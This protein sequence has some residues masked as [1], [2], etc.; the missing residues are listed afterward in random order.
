MLSI[1]YMAHLVKSSYKRREDL[2]TISSTG[3]RRPYITHA[4]ELL[5]ILGEVNTAVTG[6][7]DVL[8]AA[9]TEYDEETAHAMQKELHQ[10][11]VTPINLDFSETDPPCP[12]QCPSEKRVTD[13]HMFFCVL[14]VSSVIAD[15]IRCL[16]WLRHGRRFFA[17]MKIGVWRL[18]S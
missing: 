2:T 1:S 18:Q 16:W 8:A 3:A 9:R 7:E 6:I 14:D 10:A 12:L 15:V 4:V 5:G 17:F 13:N 11:Y